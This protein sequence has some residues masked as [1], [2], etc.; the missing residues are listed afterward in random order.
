MFVFNFTF[1]YAS[2]L[3]KGATIIVWIPPSFT[4]H[5]ASTLSTVQFWDMVENNFYI[6]LCFYFI[7][8]LRDTIHVLDLFTFHYASTLSTTCTCFSWCV[9]V[10]TFHYA[11]TLSPAPYQVLTEFTHFY[12][13]LCFY[14]ILIE[15]IGIA[16]M[17]YF[18]FHY[19]ST[20]SDDCPVAENERIVLHST[21]L[22]LYRI[23]NSPNRVTCLILHSTMLLLYR[24]QQCL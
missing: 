11:S 3:S 4:F 9:T 17:W 10:F 22:L 1:H 8:D 7:A 23:P 19:A 6:P 21:M 2:T 20:L 24:D 13:P 16:V 15:P 12:I 18:T 5:Y 14:F